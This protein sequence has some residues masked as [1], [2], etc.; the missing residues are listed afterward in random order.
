MAKR[1]VDPNHLCMGC[2]VE[3]DKKIEVCPLCGFDLAKY[4]SQCQ[5]N[6]LP[7]YEILNGK[8]L[9]G[10]VIGIGGFGITYIGWDFYQSKK[11]CIKEYFPRSVAV[12]NPDAVSYAEQ[13]SVSVQ[14]SML[15]QT[16]TIARA[17]QAYT[18]GLEAYIKEAESLSKF[19]LMPGIVSVRDFFYGNNTAYIVME[20]I[21]GIDM[22]KYAQN[23]GGRLAPN[24][25]FAVLRDV[26][27]ALHEVHKANIIHRDI[28]P[29]N[30]MLTRNGEAKLIDFGAAKNFEK[31]ENAPVLLKHGYA[32]PEQYDKNGRQGP[33]TDVYSI[34]ASIYY[35]LTG[36]RIPEAKERQKND[37]VQWLRM[38][39]VP[40]TEQVDIAL[41]KGMMLN[42]ADR[43]H[44][45]AELYLDIY[46][47]RI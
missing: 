26:L 1:L 32:P 42:I 10:R 31:S 34:C 13:I 20:Y 14:Y 38:L 30:I 36:I 28:S 43:Y 40:I 41:R 18:S 35:L 39:G 37:T 3:F 2:M 33:W 17:K 9:I 27:K 5:K 6:A 46:G 15:M 11:V 47:E 29:D 25:V 7:V 4:Q 8:Y 21:D 44:S 24:I 19:Y 16:Q 23:M 22:K 12:R 45:I